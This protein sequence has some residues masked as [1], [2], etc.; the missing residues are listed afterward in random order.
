[1]YSL[2]LSVYRT[3]VGAEFREIELC[4]VDALDGLVDVE[5]RGLVGLVLGLA[6]ELDGGFSEEAVVAV[7]AVREEQAERVL[8]LVAVDEAVPHAQ[9]PLLVGVVRL[10]LHD[11]ATPA[12][13][14][15]FCDARYV[16]TDVLTISLLLVSQ[17]GS[18]YTW[19]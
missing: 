9:V 5:E 17:Y 10:E 16:I 7:H 6:G 8:V 15:F 18:R 11:D 4:G 3:F 13:P 14:K 2:N 19:P 1:M 12:I